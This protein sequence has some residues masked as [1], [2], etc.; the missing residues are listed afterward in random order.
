[1][2]LSQNGSQ[3]I[4]YAAMYGYLEVIHLLVKKYHVDPNTL[5]DVSYILSWGQF[6]IL[7][8]SDDQ[9][10]LVSVTKQ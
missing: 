2:L 3:P 4:H 1:M 7:L 6:L 8:V 10:Y 5:R 9:V